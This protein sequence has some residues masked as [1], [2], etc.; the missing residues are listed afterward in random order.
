MFNCKSLVILLLLVAVSVGQIQHFIP[1]VPLHPE[2]LLRNVYSIQ[3]SKSFD[4]VSETKHIKVNNYNITCV[5]AH[6]H[7]SDS[8]GGYVQIVGGGIGYDYVDVK[9][10][11]QFNKGFSFVI[12]VF[13]IRPKSKYLRKCCVN[14]RTCPHAQHNLTKYFRVESILNTFILAKIAFVASLYVYIFFSLTA[15]TS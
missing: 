9:I 15:I 1:C 10:T 6:D 13:G 5:H 3:Q 12:E 11:S 2:I 8:T 4:Y 7:W 14:F